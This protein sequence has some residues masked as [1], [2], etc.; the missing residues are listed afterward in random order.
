[1][2][3]WF[4]DRF[5]GDLV[6]ERK[7]KSLTDEPE[8]GLAVRKHGNKY[9]VVIYSPGRVAGEHFVI[10]DPGLIGELTEKLNETKEAVV[11][12]MAPKFGK[13]S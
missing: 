13:R 7:L 9:S 3:K 5:A 12:D 8:L 1:M 2:F 11:K 10:F 4:K 6:Y